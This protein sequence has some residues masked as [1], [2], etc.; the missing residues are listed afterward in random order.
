MH[1]T[2][3]DVF[4][5]KIITFLEQ[6]VVKLWCYFFVTLSWNYYKF[7]YLLLWK[8]KLN[9]FLKLLVESISIKFLYPVSRFKDRPVCSLQHLARFEILKHVRRDNIDKLH[10]PNKLKSYLKQSQIFIEFNPA[11]QPTDKWIFIV[12]D[13]LFNLNNI[14]SILFNLT[15]IVNTTFKLNPTNTKN[16]I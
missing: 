16:L 1:L 14:Q 5:P 9:I 8:K 15:P 10:L 7:A 12:F 3:V 13:L 4:D 11:I 6:I 2:Y